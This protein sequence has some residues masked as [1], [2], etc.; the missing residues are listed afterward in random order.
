MMGHGERVLAAI[1]V[2][3]G[4]LGCGD[5][6]V[7]ID[8][9]GDGGPVAPRPEDGGPIADGAVDDRDMGS[10]VL[11][12]ERYVAGP[13][14]SPLTPFVAQNLREVRA[15]ASR[16]EA[17]FAKVGDSITVSAGFLRCFAGSSVDLGGRPLAA[18]LDHFRSG[19]AAGTSPFA[20]ESLAAGVG[21]HAGRVLT[22]TPP[23]LAQETAAIDPAFALVM[24]GTNDIGIVS[25]DQYAGNLLDIADRLLD[26]GI[27]PVMSTFPPRGDDPAVNRE[28][29]F[30]NLA[31]RAVAE[32]RQVPLVDLHRVLSAIPDFGLGSDGIHLST[33][34]GGACALSAEALQDGSNARNSVSAEALARLHAVLVEDGAPPDG[35]GPPLVGSGTHADPW[36]VDA[37]PFTHSANT[38]FADERV[39][40]TYT[41]CASDSDESG[42]EH[43]YRLDLAE[44][45][46]VRLNVHDRG[47][48]DVD[49]HVLSA[50]D[51]GACVAR[52]HREIEVALGAGTHFVVVDTFVSSRELAGE[53]LLT[54]G[55]AP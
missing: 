42:P 5:D 19:D 43:V 8:A 13:V 40:S 18:A 30:W 50:L 25:L 9:R 54:L 48:T 4:L 17:V 36:V 32:A 51:E 39:L 35:A 21:W 16:D 34:G 10:A 47:E 20:R 46:T 15:R 31:V 22:G 12:P 37:L 52:D 49:L 55:A 3:A 38:L 41:G 24:F 14:H 27:V 6:V 28:V 7:A 23:P 1:A 44:A 53:Y 2:C 33:F 11:H 45:A 26:A 29:P